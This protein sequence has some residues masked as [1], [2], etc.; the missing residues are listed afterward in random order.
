MT[1][2]FYRITIQE[3]LSGFSKYPDLGL[4][5]DYDLA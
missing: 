4:L 3:P 2:V 5:I 1:I